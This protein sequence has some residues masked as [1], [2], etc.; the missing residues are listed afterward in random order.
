[1]KA[2]KGTESD[3]DPESG[4]GTEAGAKGGAGLDD[5]LKSKE[6]EELE[7]DYTTAMSGNKDEFV[8]FLDKYKIPQ[9]EITN[10]EGRKNAIT[11]YYNTKMVELSGFE[12]Q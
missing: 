1:M 5:I 2:S 7:N 12:N 9:D 4:Q 11:A 6:V 3:K 10:N 8:A